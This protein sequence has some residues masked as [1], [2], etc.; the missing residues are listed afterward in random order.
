M[1]KLLIVASLLAMTTPTLAQWN[2]RHE[3]YRRQ[4][5]QHRDRG[6]SVLPGLLLGLGAAA[7]IGSLYYYQGRE[8]WDENQGFD[9]YGREVIVRVCR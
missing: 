8:C 5:F 3:P 2:H 4:H 9:H 6:N 1:R 7:A